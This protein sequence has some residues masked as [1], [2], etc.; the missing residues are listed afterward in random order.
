MEAPREPLR[1]G[2]DRG[3]D[4]RLSLRL[5]PWAQGGLSRTVLDRALDG[6][7]F[8]RGLRR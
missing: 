4:R 8:L 2:R 6:R 1:D 5:A 3:R 7:L